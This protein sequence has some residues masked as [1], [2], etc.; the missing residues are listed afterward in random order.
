[1]KYKKL[2]LVFGI[3]IPMLIVAAYGLPIPLSDTGKAHS[4]APEHSP[5]IDEY[6]NLDRVDFIHYAKPPSAAKPPKVAT[7][8]KLMGISWK[9][10]PVNYA[11][12]PSTQEGLEQ[13]FVI[14]AMS[15]AA[16]TWDNATLSRELFNDAYSINPTVTYGFDGTNAIVF[17]PYSDNNV[18]AV[19]SVWYDRRTRG[20]VEFDIL[21]NEYYVWGAANMPGDQ[22]DVQ[23]IATHELG[24]AIGLADIYTDSCSDVTMYGYSWYEETK[25]QTLETADITGLQSIYGN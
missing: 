9:S 19:T 17:G 14:A 22:M 24:H 5:V 2:L 6:F 18:I 4:Q 8:Y 21:F 11:I 23:N 1:M 3:V 25:K 12:N 7:C 15:G 13:D 16:E 10:L 20:I